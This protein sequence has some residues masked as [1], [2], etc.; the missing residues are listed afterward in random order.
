MTTPTDA[1]KPSSARIYDYFLDGEEWFGA[2]EAFAKILMA[3][4]MWVRD[5]C[6][7]NR[8]FLLR[9]AR[10]VAEK[11]VTQVL[12][13]GC[14]LPTRPNVH[15]TVRSVQP[16][17]RVAYVDND[18]TVVI[19]NHAN[20]DEP[21]G[22]VTIEG[23]LKQ[24]HDILN[25]PQIRELLDF[26]QPIAL[27]LVG[28]WHFLPGPDTGKIMDVLCDALAPGSYVVLSH[29]CSD[30]MTKE[31]KAA[32]QDVYRQTSNPAHPRSTEEIRL[33]VDGLELLSPGLVPVAEW[34]PVDGDPYPENAPAVIGAVGMISKR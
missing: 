19:H 18:L 29:A 17:A 1:S 10:K 15:E 5:A 13:I 16:G 25:N 3:D 20:V 30:A 26:T 28:V 2:D 22:V 4:D 7:A 34:N 9:A 11:G 23:D 33:L 32:G 14:G 24:P 6:R 31:K 8:G 21:D 12:E 27:I